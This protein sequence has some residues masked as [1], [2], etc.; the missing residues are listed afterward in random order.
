[1]RTELP[2]T[3]DVVVEQQ[4]REG[5]SDGANDERD[6]TMRVTLRSSSPSR[7]LSLSRGRSSSRSM[8]G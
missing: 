5:E 7:C 6:S 3:M 2:R 4:V 1:M 8:E